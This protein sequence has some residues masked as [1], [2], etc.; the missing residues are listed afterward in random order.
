MLE[1]Y[2]LRKTATQ[3][4]QE[5]AHAMYKEDAAMRVLARIMKE[6]DEARSA[7]A[8]IRQSM[9]LGPS[10]PQ[11]ST[12][13]QDATMDVDAQ[14]EPA[15]SGTLPADVVSV[16]DSTLARYAKLFKF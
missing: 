5:L 14:E 9:G 15:Q 7:L 6:R 12:S 8:S 4:R 11:P 16:I 2:E 13:T 10:D 1:V 3:L